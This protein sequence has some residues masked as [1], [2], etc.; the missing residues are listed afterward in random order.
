MK[1]EEESRLELQQARDAR[2]AKEGEVSVLRGNIEKV[3]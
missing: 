3:R 2:L 1:K